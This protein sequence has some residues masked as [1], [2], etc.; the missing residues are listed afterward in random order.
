MNLE[1]EK[2]EKKAGDKPSLGSAVLALLLRFWRVLRHN[3]LWKLLA[4][5]LAICLWAGLITQDP[6]LTRERVFSD[7]PVTIMGADTLQRNGLV[8]LTNFDEEPLTVRLR[9]DIPQRE[10]TTAT[11]AYFN[12]RIDLSKI[13]STGTQTLRINTST[14]TTYGSVKEMT[15]DSLEI[16]V[17][18]YVTNYRVPVNVER[19]G[20]F[21]KGYYGTAASLDPATVSVSG[22]ESIVA[23]IAR[24][25]VDFDVSRLPAQ[26]GLIR[27]VVPMRFEDLDGNPVASDLVDVTSAGVL[28][29]S[30]VV[31]QTLYATKTLPLSSL[32]LT[33]GTPAEGYEVRS[34]TA[35]PNI[36]VAAGDEV[37]LG[38]LDALFLEQSVDVE[39]KNESFT[40]EVHIRKPSELV[41]ISTDTIALY[42]EI[43]PIMASK[44]FES[45][46]LTFK[47]KA[48]ER[49]GRSE[50]ETVSCSLTGPGF[51]LNAL[52]AKQLSAYVDISDLAPGEYELPILLHVEGAEDKDFSYSLTPKNASVQV[53]IS[54]D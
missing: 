17:E 12:P 24:V 36:L 3:W 25:V 14:S 44:E 34:V 53:T 27:T 43:G 10:Y 15:P 30:I 21:P 41:Y 22:P 18:K 2:K 4:I 26:A 46:P 54:K 5:V 50:V 51:A 6:T 39:G 45:I 28:L 20:Q 13:T 40:A 37:G 52:S 29:R 47:D 49:H 23:Q 16:T 48:G 8:V 35:T 31:E 19:T 33:T 38:A 1:P 42:V 32:G 11:A 7:V 9:A